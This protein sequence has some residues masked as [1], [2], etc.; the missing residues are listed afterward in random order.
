MNNEVKK[1]PDS[2]SKNRVTNPLKQDLIKMDVIKR[3]K[4][5]LSIREYA[6]QVWRNGETKVVETHIN[7]LTSDVITRL[8]S[9]RI[10]Y[11]PWLNKT[12]PLN[13]CNILEVGCGTG[14]SL[15]AL[16]E[17]GANVT[18]IDIHE[19]STKVAKDLCEIFN[20][21]AT[22]ITGNA[23]DVFHEI[24]NKKFDL[25]LFFASIEHMLYEERIDCLRK[26]YSILTADAYLVI[27]ETPNR[28]WHFDDH[29]SFLPFFHWLPDNLAFDYFKLSNRNTNNESLHED[30]DDEY[31]HLLRRGRGFSFHELEIALN[32]PAEKLEIVD[33]MKPYMLTKPD[34]A[35]HNLL[36]QF[37]PKISEGFFYPNIDI[38]I[39]K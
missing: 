26:Y 31:L 19:P 33:Y 30:S 16:A 37:H 9:T 1:T 15:V 21:K 24:K 3:K 4:I 12:I 36:M 17:Q 5:E 8:E 32:F 18:G 10:T 39:K 27:I 7:Y 13:G 14:S 29:T 11:I 35:F 38:I 22:L 23:C 25:V 34:E 20:V 28:L 2:T 6:D